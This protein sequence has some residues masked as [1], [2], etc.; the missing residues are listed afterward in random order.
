[1]EIVSNKAQLVGA[2]KVTAEGIVIV[3]LPPHVD[4]STATFPLEAVNAPTLPRCCAV[5]VFAMPVLAVPL[6]KA[7]EPCKV[8]L[9]RLSNCA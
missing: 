3:K 8:R 2:R 5:H 6:G 7:A 9:P 1:M 4:K